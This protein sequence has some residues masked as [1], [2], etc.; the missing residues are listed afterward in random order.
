MESLQRRFKDRPPPP[1]QKLLKNLPLPVQI[2][3]NIPIPIS[4]PAQDME[5][6]RGLKLQLCRWRL[7]YQDAYHKG[8]LFNLPNFVPPLLSAHLR[9]CPDERAALDGRELQQRF[10]VARR[11]RATLFLR[12]KDRGLATTSRHQVRSERK[13]SMNQL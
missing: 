12:D 10:H 3:C 1:P 7:D 8:E 13:R 9:G 6:L 11:S 4:C 2:P 5:T